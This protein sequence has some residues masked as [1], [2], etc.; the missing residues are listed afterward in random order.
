L[1][2]NAIAIKEAREESTNNVVIDEGLREDWRYSTQG[3]N[4]HLEYGG[5]ITFY[6]N[7]VRNAPMRQYL[8]PL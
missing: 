2:R 6:L 1:R 5:R 4:D 8:N 7:M 3:R